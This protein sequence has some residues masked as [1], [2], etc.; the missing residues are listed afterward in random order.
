[1]SFI[2]QPKWRARGETT[3][4]T[5][6]I[7]DIARFGSNVAMTKVFH[8]SYV[9]CALLGLIHLFMFVEAYFRDEIGIYPPALI[10]ISGAT[11][12]LLLASI[13]FPPK[14]KLVA[15]FLFAVCTI[16]T[17]VWSMSSWPIDPTGMSFSDGIIQGIILLI[18]V[19]V[20]VIGM[21]SGALLLRRHPDNK[22]HIEEA[23]CL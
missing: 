19:F 17:Y 4:E 16:S 3:A 1:V 5:D 10:F 13:F 18:F 20:P 8:G 14:G 22:K 2:A 12:M 7:A 6:P 11:S 23:G 21:V 9:I 15:I